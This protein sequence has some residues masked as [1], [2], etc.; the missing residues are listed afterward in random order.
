MSAG[1]GDDIAAP[2]PAAFDESNLTRAVLRLA[3]PVVIQQVS[4]TSVQ[5]V[6]TFLVGHLGQDALAGVGLASIL[7]WFPLS[8][9]FAIGIGATAVVARNMGAG[10]AD[11][12]TATLRSALLLAL[13]WGAAMAVLYFV[14]A[15]PMLR[16][17]GAEPEAM[18]KGV[19]YMQ[20]AAFGIPF[21]T[22]LYASNA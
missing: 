18:D 17:M 6:D 2:A 13:V 22:L 12:A 20:A 21:Y 4:F 8:G 16:V 7:Y 15:A 9:M 14:A 10:H 5:L 3:W 1:A 19:L 11:R